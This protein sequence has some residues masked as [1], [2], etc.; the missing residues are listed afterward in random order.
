M[1]LGIGN[2]LF[3]G[4]LVGQLPPDFAHRPLLVALFLD[5]FDP[6]VGYA[7]RHAEVESDTAG[8]ERGGQAGHARDVLGDGESVR[9][10]LMDEDVGKAEIGH[11]ILVH[12]AVEIER[13]V[14]E[15]LAETVV[16]VEHRG[17]A[18]EAETVDVILF[19]PVFDIRQEEVFRLVLAVVE[20]AGSP[21]RM[22]SLRTV[23][24]VEVLATVEAR[25]AFRLVVD[26]VAV[27]DVHHH[28]D[29][30]SV[31][32]VDKALELL[33]R[34]E[35]GAQRIEI[36]HLVAEGT[37]V[38]VLLQSHDLDRVVTE[39]L[40]LRQDIP[41]EILERGHAFLLRAHADMAF[42]DQRMGPFPGMAVLPGIGLGGGPDLC[43][44]EL[45]HLVLHHAGHVGRKA[46]PCSAR[47][48]DPEFVEFPVVEEH[49]R[50][51]KLPVAVS[52]GLQGIG[53]GL[54]PVVAVA[55]EIDLRRVRRPL[56]EHP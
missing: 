27:D 48:L 45:G 17:H 19:H 12:A 34:A 49:F 54:F 30:L 46:L 21:G 51:R 40:D 4:A 16:P 11:R 23:V 22:A 20:A 13:I 18:V 1:A 36:G 2:G 31:G 15:I 24:E 33:G 43:G 56:P 47:P 35:T 32:V 8:G 39:L 53:L 5:P 25:E 52:D 6:V 28:R 10:H 41:A 38:R 44:E 9:V 55:D 42:I 7:H 50:N 37:I 3:V 26:A 14:A 29:A